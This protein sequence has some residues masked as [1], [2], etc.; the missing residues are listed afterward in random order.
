MSI[1]YELLGAVMRT[2]Y[3]VVGDYGFTIIIFTI[4][5]KTAI[6]SLSIKIVVQL[7][8]IPTKLKGLTK[9]I[10]IYHSIIYILMTMA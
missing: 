10:I 6:L 3:Q 2:I 4:L 1:I 8:L 7:R 9:P 5:V